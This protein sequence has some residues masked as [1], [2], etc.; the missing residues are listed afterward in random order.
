MLVF[1]TS[2]QWISVRVVAIGFSVNTLTETLLAWLMSLAGRPVQGRVLVIPNFFRIT[3][4]APVLLGLFKAL[5]T[6]L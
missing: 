3:K 4:M 6:V 1:L 5:E 2:L